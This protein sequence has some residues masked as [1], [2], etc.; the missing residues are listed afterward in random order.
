M[1][2]QMLKELQVSRRLVLMEVAFEM[3]CE[4][5]STTFPYSFFLSHLLHHLYPVVCS[6]L[7]D[8]VDS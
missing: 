4:Y 7:K 2:P 3:A 8:P 6:Y 5:I 1:T